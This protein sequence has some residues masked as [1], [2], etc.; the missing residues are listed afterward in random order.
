MGIS[1]SASYQLVPCERKKKPNVKT[2]VCDTE[3]ELGAFLKM[4][5]RYIVIYLDFHLFKFI[6]I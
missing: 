6:C 4:A 2:G 3:V 1:K 5:T